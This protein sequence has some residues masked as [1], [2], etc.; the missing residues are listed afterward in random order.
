[1]VQRRDSA[2]LRYFFL[3]FWLMHDVSI[4]SDFFSGRTTNF[5]TDDDDDDDSPTRILI[6]CF[7]AQVEDHTGVEKGSSFAAGRTIFCPTGFGGSRRS[8]H[9]YISTVAPRTASMTTSADSRCLLVLTV[10]G[11][12]LRPRPC[13][14]PHESCWCGDG[15]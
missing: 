10:V 6:C 4:I 14:R 11:L 2:V 3:C 1:M 12:G 7:V 8:R 13:K 15:P 9:G 5:R